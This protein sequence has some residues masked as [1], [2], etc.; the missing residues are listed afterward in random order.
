MGSNDIPPPHVPSSYHAICTLLL[1]TGGIGY[2][3]TYF[4]MTRQSLHDR[5]YAMPLLSLAFNFG[6]E[7]IF[8]LYVA[9]SFQ[10]KTIFTIWM[11]LDLGL[12]YGVVKYGKNEW[13]HA[14]IVGRH[15][16]KI[17][18]VLVAWWCWALWAISTWWVD[19]RAPVSPK[20][21]KIYR[22]VVGPD[23]TELGFWTAL[24]AQVVLSCLLLA[25]IIVRGHSGGAS[26]SIWVTR[27]VGSLSGLNLYYG[28]C[29]YVWPEAHGYYMNPFAVCLWVTWPLADLA[30]F[31]LLRQVRKTEIVLEDGRKV[32]QKNAVAN[33]KVS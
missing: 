17:L 16:G 6:W 22:G 8:S 33:G 23:T 25:Q 4:L 19:E 20:E 1:G 7:I 18:C 14:P 27:F 29:W 11:L 3:I 21:G 26:Y 32:G 31:V 28:Y 12:V 9:E 24:T 13:T 15:I 30:Y 2:T 5:T 10:E